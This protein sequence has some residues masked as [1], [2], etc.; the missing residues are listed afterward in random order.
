M[1]PEKTIDKVS[2]AQE[3]TTQPRQAGTSPVAKRTLPSQATT[4]I[5]NVE[6]V[7]SVQGHEKE[8]AR[9]AP[10][11]QKRDD[12]GKSP[13]AA[14]SVDGMEER[15]EQDGT[16]TSKRAAVSIDHEDEP[17][18][19]RQRLEDTLHRTGDTGVSDSYVAG[20]MNDVFKLLEQAALRFH[21]DA[22]STLR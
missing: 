14:T 15:T 10:F 21:L 19:K 18:H 16:T 5:I 7:I 12:E 3:T 1:L 8:V 2:E 4:N 9:V 6:N 17:Q 20:Q 13:T 11:V 22:D